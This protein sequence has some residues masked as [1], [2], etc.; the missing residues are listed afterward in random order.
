M[1]DVDAQVDPWRLA[2]EKRIAGLEKFIVFVAWTSKDP[3][4][5]QMCDEILA[6]TQQVDARAPERIVQLEDF[7]A[8]V[9]STSEDP[10]YVRM[11]NKLLAT[12]RNKK[13]SIQLT[14]PLP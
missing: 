5:V 2:Q 7:I 3:V 1:I 12:K 10:V 14:L 8:F 4:L 11:A 9:G 6:K 13:R